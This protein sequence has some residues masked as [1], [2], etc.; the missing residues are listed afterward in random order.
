MGEVKK[1]ESKSVRQL[2]YTH[3]RVFL[4]QP[5]ITCRTYNIFML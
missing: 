2:Q 1:T 5:V 3:R 4:F